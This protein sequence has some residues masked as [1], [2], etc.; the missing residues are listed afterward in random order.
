MT[1]RERHRL[2]YGRCSSPLP[3]RERKR[4]VLLN[5]SQLLTVAVQSLRS[6]S[7]GSTFVA[8]RDGIKLAK[9]DRKST[10]LNSSHLGI[11]YA[12]FC[13]KKKKK[14]TQSTLAQ[15]TSTVSSLGPSAAASG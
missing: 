11:S 10:R 13:L 8:R 4:P 7:N 6:A 5:F 2:P 3:N 1:S 12:V 9:R 14:R 15:R